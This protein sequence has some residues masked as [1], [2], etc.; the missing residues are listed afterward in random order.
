MGRVVTGGVVAGGVPVPG[1]APGTFWVCT[2]GGAGG[3][4][5]ALT[6]AEPN[7]AAMQA[8]NGF[9]ECFI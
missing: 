5:K 6:E 8:A 7:T 2:G 3:A 1:C 4:P 9:K